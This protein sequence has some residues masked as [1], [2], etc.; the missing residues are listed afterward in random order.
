LGKVPYGH[1]KTTTFIT[2]LRDDALTA[3]FVLD[4]PVD[5]EYSSPTSDSSSFPLFR[6]AILW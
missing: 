2:A 4:G 5:G 3:P 1:W 6:A